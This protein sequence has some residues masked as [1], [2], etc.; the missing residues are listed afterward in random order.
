MHINY[1]P[2]LNLLRNEILSLLTQHQENVALLVRT[3]ATQLTSLKTKLDALEKEHLVCYSQTKVVESLYFLEL[4]RRFSQ[5]P[6]AT[7]ATNAWL[8]DPALTSFTYWLESQDGIYWITGKVCVQR[9]A[10]AVPQAD[11]QSPGRQWQINPYEVRLR[12]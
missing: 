9:W 12:T 11:G 1:E 7:Q 8:F 3:E 4:R 2:K 10:L 5:I 6:E